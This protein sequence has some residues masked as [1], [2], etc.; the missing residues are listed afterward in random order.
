MSIGPESRCGHLQEELTRENVGAVC[1][2][3]PAWN[4]TGRCIWHA[5]EDAKPRDAFETAWPEPG[6][7]LDGAILRGASL[8]GA[9]FS[10][11]RFIGADFAGA[12]V[13]DADFS[14]ADLR[15]ATF[16]DTDARRASFDRSTIEDAQFV[17]A[18]LREGSFLEARLDRAIFS[19]TPVDRK[20]R[21]GERVVYEQRLGDVGDRQRWTD[22]VEAAAWSY[23]ELQQLFDDN[24][25]PER[26]LH[27]YRQEMDLRRRVAWATKDW[28]RAFTLAG[29]HWIMRYGTS[30]WRVVASSL[31]LILVCALLYPLTGGIQAVG[32][33]QAI[34]YTLDDPSRASV[35]TIVTVF[36]ESL[37]FSIVT[38]ATLGYGDIQPVGTWARLLA[39]FESLTGSLLMALLVFVL[40]RSVR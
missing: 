33:N 23:R 4:H 5:D 17:N 11:C 27:Y 24:A 25:I 40:T 35:E 21:F 34:T 19:N 16:R 14:G 13:R 28:A 31:V 1:C 10:A 18:D 36:L 3:R 2:W 15:R 9:E 8:A 26:S 32:V 6:E 12:I 20:T 38:F 30:P 37:Y 7:R 39:G 22:L 29:S